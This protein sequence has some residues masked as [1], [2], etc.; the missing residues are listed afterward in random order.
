MPS[1]EEDPILEAYDST[2]SMGSIFLDNTAAD[3]LFIKP[4]GNP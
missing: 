4:S 1:N 3:F 2:E